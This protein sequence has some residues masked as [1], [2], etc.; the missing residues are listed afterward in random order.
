MRYLS[1]WLPVLFL[2][3][4]IVILSSR[5]NLSVPQT[6]PHLDK[7]MH[8][9]EY[10]ALGALLFRALYLS[11]GRAREAVI[12]ALALAA[13]LGL[14]DE[15]LQSHVPGRDSSIADWFA[16]LAGATSGIWAGILAVRKGLRGWT[17]G[18]PGQKNEERLEAR[19][20]R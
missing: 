13:L 18:P 8:F 5:P 15:K 16:D 11:G 12:G 4:V 20:P 7:V 19:T 2:E 9:M 14:V 3:I 1:A 6:V 17:F 10:A